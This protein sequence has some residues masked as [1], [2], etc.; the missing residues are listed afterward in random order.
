MGA[1]CISPLS[2]IQLLTQVGVWTGTYIRDMNKE[3]EGG[4]GGTETRRNRRSVYIDRENVREKGRVSGG[5]QR[6]K[7]SY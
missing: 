6:E 3:R 1:C 5:G 4:K 7:A 2:H